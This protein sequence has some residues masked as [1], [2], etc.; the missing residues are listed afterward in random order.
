MD[1]QTKTILSELHNAISELSK[2]SKTAYQSAN[3]T[4]N[5]TTIRN[6]MEPI[7]VSLAEVKK[8]LELA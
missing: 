2:I 4:F 3:P 1:T 7:Q 6:L 5:E 8:C